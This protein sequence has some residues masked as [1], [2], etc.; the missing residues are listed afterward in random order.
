MNDTN[1]LRLARRVR[2]A[3]EAAERYLLKSGGTMTGPITTPNNAVGINVGDD[4]RLAD[5]NV[6]NTMFVEGQQNSD[7][8]Y[9]NFSQTSGN[10]L[11]AVNGGNLTWRGARVWDAAGLPYETGTWTPTLYGSTTEGTP[12]YMAR[13][14]TYVRIGDTVFLKGKCFVTNKGGMAGSLQIKGLPFVPNE[15]SAGIV[16]AQSGYASAQITLHIEAGLNYI[17]IRKLD[18]ELNASEVS[19]FFGFWSMFLVMKIA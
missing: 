17:V 6:A 12:T 13:E 10:A 1:F 18:G 19:D 2:E 5:R 14:G 15:T 3:E 7:R 9:I 8:G 4:A 11:G 16:G